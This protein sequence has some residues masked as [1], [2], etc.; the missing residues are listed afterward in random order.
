[1]FVCGVCQERYF[2]CFVVGGWFHVSVS[3][4][5]FECMLSHGSVRFFDVLAD[6]P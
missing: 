4:D 2:E 5:L 6:S 1:M 3:H